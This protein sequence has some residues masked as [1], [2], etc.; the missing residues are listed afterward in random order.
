MHTLKFFAGNSH[1]ELANSICGHLGILPNNAIVS[2]FKDGET[3][4]ELNDCVR[5]QDV[6]LFQTLLSPEMSQNE[7]LM[8]LLIMA[9]AVSRASARRITAVVPYL[10]YARQDRKTAP[11][12]PITASLVADLMATAGIQNLIS[13][14]FHSNQIQGF[15]P[16][17]MTIAH[18]F[19]STILLP[20][21]REN[22]DSDLRLISPD[23]GGVTRTRAYAKRL[24]MKYCLIDKTRNGAS[25]IEKMILKGSVRGKKTGVI[26]DLISTGGTLDRAG[27]LILRRGGLSVSALAAHAAFTKETVQTIQNSCLQKVVVTD[28]VPLSEEAKQCDKIVQLKTGK[29]FADAIRCIHEGKSI[30]PLCQV[31]HF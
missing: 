1:P 22:F 11:R 16:K 23:A 19:S 27:R 5:D 17:P 10:A 18:L 30:S 21:I 24:R 13:M 4:V 20:Y 26:D 31:Q 8:E 29:L 2:K 15:F 28:T 12:T 9:D 14:E 7:C 6:F 3:R 25:M